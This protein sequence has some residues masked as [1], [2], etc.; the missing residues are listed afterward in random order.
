MQVC[1][2]P[3]KLQ[4]YR[5]HTQAALAK[6]TM[7]LRDLKS[8][9]G[10]LQFSTIAVPVGKAFLRRLHDLTIGIT[11]PHYYVTISKSA[12]SDLR[13]WMHFLDNFNGVSVIRPRYHYNSTSIKMCSDAS[14]KGYGATYGRNWIEGL[15]PIN[16]QSLNIAIL[17]LYPIYLLLAIFAHKLQHSH[18]TFY[19]DNQ[20]VVHIINKQS[21]KCPS[22]MSILR[23]LVLLLL[24][25][26]IILQ[27]AH[28]PGI[29]NTLCDLISRQMVTPELLHHY[30]MSPSPTPVPKHLRPEAFRLD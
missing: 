13:M 14:K 11:K 4:K 7:P 20:A 30:G 17:E 28:I 19:T 29:N 21:S 6:R 16:W 22:I 2:P 9:I 10:Q 25:N 23:P 27:A 3:E 18:I 12:T 1:L 8:L 15:W 26:N 5:T 24:H